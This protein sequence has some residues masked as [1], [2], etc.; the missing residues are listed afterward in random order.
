MA[1]VSPNALAGRRREAEAVRNDLVDRR[2]HER[3]SSLFDR[4]VETALGNRAAAFEWLNRAFDARSANLFLVNG[5]LKFDALR[6][7]PR[8]QDLLRRMHFPP[9]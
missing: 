8:F 3:P 2:R 9:E 5:E 4:V 7:D 6:A 1:T